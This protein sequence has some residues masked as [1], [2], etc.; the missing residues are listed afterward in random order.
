LR[1]PSDSRLLPYKVGEPEIDQSVGSS[2]VSALLEKASSPLL[3]ALP[4]FERQF[5]RNLKKGEYF[6]SISDQIVA[7]CKRSIGEQGVQIDALLAALSNLQDHYAAT[8]VAFESAQGKLTAQQERHQTLL[9]SFES[10]LERLQSIPLH[11]SLVSSVGGQETIDSIVNKGMSNSVSGIN[12]L[13]SPPLSPLLSHHNASKIRSFGNSDDLAD[14]MELR[15]SGSMSGSPIGRRIGATMT[16]T[17]HSQQYQNQQLQNQQQNQPQNQLQN[18]Q[19]SNQNTQQTQQSQQQQLQNSQQNTQQNR[20]IP[21]DSSPG[22]FSPPLDP[23]GGPTG[24]PGGSI[25]E[26]QTGP[27]LDMGS[28]DEAF[29][30]ETG[31]ISVSSGD[32]KPEDERVS[33]LACVPVEKERAWAKQCDEVHSNVDQKLAQLLVIFKQVCIYHYPELSSHYP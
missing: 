31:D 21:L 4:D 18:Q 29:P 16:A 17:Q 32:S 23:T 22:M 26:S 2:D 6:L 10:D 13:A 8:K 5:L 27:N 12:I 28:F 24:G 30:F 20:Q 19:I 7:S 33:L 3:R 9:D 15:V 11:T 14:N 25:S 1:L